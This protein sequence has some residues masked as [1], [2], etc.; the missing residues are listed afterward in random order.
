MVSFT[1][2]ADTGVTTAA[3]SALT[4]ATAAARA[5]GLQVDYA[6]AFYPAGTSSTSELP[7]LILIPELLAIGGTVDWHRLRWL[8]RYVSEPDIEGARLAA[9][10]SPPGGQGT[11]PA[12]DAEAEQQLKPGADNR[13]PSLRRVSTG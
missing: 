13:R 5:A 4:S 8:D 3:L 9:I 7:R 11:T 10:T 2:A 1:A 6:G 12:D